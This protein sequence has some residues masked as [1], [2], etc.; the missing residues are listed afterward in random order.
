MFTEWWFSLEAIPREVIGGL[1]GGAI[2]AMLLGTVRYFRGW[3]DAGQFRG[4]DFHIA[5][6]MYTRIDDPDL[7][8]ADRA[9]AVR[10]K[11]SYV[12]ELLWL[13]EEAPLSDL[14]TNPYVLRQVSNAMGRAR[15]EGLLLGAI[16]ERV[17]LFLMK[18][19]IG[20]HN[21]IPKSDLTDAY[22]RHVGAGAGERVHGIAPPTHEHYRGSQHRRVLRAMFIA[23]S[24]LQ[25]GQLPAK[26]DIYFKTGGQGNRY[27]TIAAITAAYHENPERFARCQAYF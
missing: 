23:D 9:R 26:E 5:A 25:A 1:I 27:D 6:T 10:A 19:I 18:K 2:A 17:E 12:Q 14:L 15:N 3:Y 8:D 21:R 4:A 16:H 24:Q 20:Y 11:K 13:G 7:S 22:K